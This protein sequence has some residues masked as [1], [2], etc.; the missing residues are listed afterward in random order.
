MSSKTNSLWFNLAVYVIA[1]AIALIP[2]RNT[3]NLFYAAALFMA[4]ST[5]VIFVIGSIIKDTSLFDPYWSAA[6]PVLLLAAMVKH[7]YYSMNAWVL[8]GAILIWATRLTVN[9]AVAY[10]G[11]GHEDWRYADLRKKLPAPLFFLVNL[12]GLMGFPS[13]LIYLGLIGA[14]FVIQVEGFDPKI[15]PGIFM[16][17]A[18]TL[19][20]HVADSAVHKFLKETDKPGTTCRESVWK[21]SRHPN[22]LGEMMVWTGIFL[23]FVMLRPDIWY[24][25]LGVIGIWILFPFISIPMMEKHNL[26]RRNDYQDYQKTTS[27]LFLMPQKKQK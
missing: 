16:I 12:F 19:L 23:S 21:Y 10:K 2:F 7:H 4:V 18:G 13:L 25:G 27:K 17:L 22:Y 5:L 1:F 6:P 11:V 15:L 8:F 26:S 9:W 14:L 3:D 20:E 24:Y